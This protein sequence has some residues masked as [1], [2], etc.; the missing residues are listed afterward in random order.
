MDSG[1]AE[2]SRPLA[3]GEGTVSG[4]ASPQGL[5]TFEE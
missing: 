5:S 3:A 2:F 4:S 1:H